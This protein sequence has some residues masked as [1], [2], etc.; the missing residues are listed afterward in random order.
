MMQV[1]ADVGESIADDARSD[2]RRGLRV[3][4]K[5]PVKVFDPVSGRYFPGITLD[6]S[7]TGLR[8]GLPLSMPVFEGRVV[9]VVVGTDVGRD[10]LTQ[11]KQMIPAR[12]VWLDRRPGTSREVRCGVEFIPHSRA[13][14]A[15]A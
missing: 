15:A 14:V 8:L 10:G 4:R 12:I 13:E 3:P 7:G 11:R 5:R 6:I 9:T 2:R 1:A